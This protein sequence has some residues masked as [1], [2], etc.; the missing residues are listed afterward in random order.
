MKHKNP[1][2][3]HKPTGSKAKP[4]KNKAS[5]LAEEQL[6]ET[7]TVSGLSHEGRGIAKHAGKTLFISGALPGE[8]VSYEITA[9]HRRYDEARCKEVL[10]P[11]H[12]RVVP[13]CTY[14]EQCGG[15]DLQHLDHA[16]QI[17]I[18]QNLVLDQL[19]RL[20]QVQPEI[21]ET[22]LTS[23]PW[24]YRRS[25]RLGVN[26]RHRDDSV[27][28]G[29]RRKS[30]NKLINIEQCPV[31]H[32]ELNPL[33]TALWQLLSASGDIKHITHA[34]TTLSESAKVLVLRTVKPLQPE[35]AQKLLQFSQAQDCLIYLDNGQSKQ[36]LGESQ[37][38][39]YSLANLQLQ[40]QPGD[41]IQVNAA[42]NQKMIA[43]AI[44]W[45]ALT[46][47]DQVLDLFCGIG[48]FSLP[49][50]QK[51]GKVVGVEGVE[52]MVKRAANNVALNAL[53]NCTFYRADLSKDLTATSWY[54]DSYQQGFNKIILDPPRSGAADIIPQLQKH[55]AE[56]ILYIS[57]N[58]AA[59]ARDAQLL[60]RQGYT[61][62]RFCVMDMF[63]QTS[64]VESMLLF[65]KLSEKQYDKKPQKIANSGNNN[66]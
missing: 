61:A 51:A 53:D 20:G 54:K 7:L 47:Q 34:E 57:C 40:F 16:R 59:L 63:P 21:I 32:D 22:A 10:T 19:K 14:Y 43:T 65:E 36:A 26:Q 6:P 11:S 23:E 13:A 5:P 31:L 50:A 58:P 64:H 38:L 60:I 42:V 9:T 35:L 28:V 62:T 1:L 15:C 3:A 46:P 52:E 27:L 18:K 29:F 48:N 24:G 25:A 41:F 39:F 33:I 30:S 2:F 56:K 8:T 55:Q 45:L 66:P 44:Q 4:R 17:D 37:P 12:D 49:V